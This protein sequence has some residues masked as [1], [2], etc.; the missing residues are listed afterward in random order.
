MRILELNGSCGAEKWFN[1]LHGTE[2]GV[3]PEISDPARTVASQISMSYIWSVG[4]SRHELYDKI[5]DFYRGEAP[6]LSLQGN[7]SGMNLKRTD[8]GIEVC[9]TS[10]N[11]DDIRITYS[12]RNIENDKAAYFVL[13]GNERSGGVMDY[14]MASNYLYSDYGEADSL[15][16]ELVAEERGSGHPSDYMQVIA[17]DKEKFLES[18]FYKRESAKHGYARP[19]PKQPETDID[20]QCESECAL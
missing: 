11:H 18:D 13:K 15:R 14:S 6:E 5:H 19:L 3:S 17:V 7:G 1:Q 9:V 2:S 8:N 4:G 16:R 20:A 12:E 10:R